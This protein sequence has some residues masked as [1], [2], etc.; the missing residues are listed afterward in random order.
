[1]RMLNAGLTGGIAG[2]KS[3]VSDF[4]RR[5]GAFIIDHDLLT[6][7]VQEPDGA[8]WRGIVNHFGET[9]LNPDRSIDRE[10]LGKIVFSDPGELRKLNEIVHPAVYAQ[11]KSDIARIEAQKKDAL[12]ISDIPLLIEVGWTGDVDLLI[13]VFIPPEEQI[14]RL[15]NRN[16]LSLEDAHKRLDSQMPIADKLKYADFVIDNSGTIEETRKKVDAVWEKL[17]E[18]EQ[19]KRQRM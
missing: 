3:T 13:V 10:A 5:K 17:I 8:A 9:V 14:K 19:K 7:K 18:L 4:L 2:G 6:R 11:W 16:G 1:M 12:I 15:M